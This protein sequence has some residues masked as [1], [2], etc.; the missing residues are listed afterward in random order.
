MVNLLLPEQKNSVKKEYIARVAVLLLVFVI[1]TFALL[2]CLLVPAYISLE[3]KEKVA[4]EYLASQ[5][6]EIINDKEDLNNIINDTNNKLM[7]L[8][9]EEDSGGFLVH[10][11]IFNA[12]IDT[13]KDVN[14]DSITYQNNGV[15]APTVRVSGISDT[16]E[17]LQLFIKRLEGEA[18][19]R[20]VNAPV[21]NFVQDKNIEFS[22]DI[23]LQ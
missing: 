21:S 3:D 22:L 4:K 18:N 1:V 15:T 8:K 2:V 19:F 13:R 12:I 5:S 16:R 9:I 20:N 17:D 23:S 10:Q 7:A 11:D 14:I 6:D